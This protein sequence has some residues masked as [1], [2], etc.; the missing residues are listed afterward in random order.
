MIDLESQLLLV[1]EFNYYY[2]ILLNVYRL[3]RQNMLH[4]EFYKYFN[5]IVITAMML[6]KY[7]I[8]FLQKHRHY[9]ISTH[10]NIKLII[11]EFYP[12]SKIYMSAAFTT[13]SEYFETKHLNNDLID[14]EDSD[15]DIIMFWDFVCMIEQFYTKLAKRLIILSRAH[16]HSY[17][18]MHELKYSDPLT[19]TQLLLHK[20]KQMAILSK[21]ISYFQYSYSSLEYFMTFCKQNKCNINYSNSNNS[22]NNTNSNNI[23]I[24]PICLDKLDFTSVA[25]IHYNNIN[26]I[27]NINNNI[28]ENNADSLKRRHL[29]HRKCIFDSVIYRN[30]LCPLD[31]AEIFDYIHVYHN[32]IST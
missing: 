20:N 7:F 14:F 6:N 25:I 9:D 18:L 8:K 28:I 29:F 17:R 26:N 16:L 3:I 31:R 15:D 24:C 2:K 10:A 23:D 12:S 5:V 13:I 30:T 21:I 27:N 4:T 11:N 1:K 32:L 19:Y 22:N